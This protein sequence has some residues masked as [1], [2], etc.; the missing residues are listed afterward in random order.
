MRQ[1]SVTIP[2]GFESECDLND[3]SHIPG[4]SSSSFFSSTY[5]NN[6]RDNIK[7]LN[8]SK[9]EMYRVLVVFVFGKTGAQIQ[10][11]IYKIKQ[12]ANSLHW[13]S[14]I[15]GLQQ[16]AFQARDCSSAVP[17]ATV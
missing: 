6:H 13:A 4:S 10:I 9:S 17:D 12:Y 16:Q 8:Y 2:L 3:S 11:F 15:L 1:N 14:V 5:N 7:R